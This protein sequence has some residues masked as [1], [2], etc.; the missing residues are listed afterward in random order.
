[1]RPYYQGVKNKD[2]QNFPAANHYNPKFIESRKKI[3]SFTGK[4]SQLYNKDL[5]KYPNPQKYVTPS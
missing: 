4:R 2:F 3:I 1:M 5:I